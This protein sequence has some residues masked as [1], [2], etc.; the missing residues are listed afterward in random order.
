VKVEKENTRLSA[1]D[2]SNQLACPHLTRL[3]LAVARGVRLAPQWRNP[4]TWVLQQHGL[5]HEQNYLKHLE[6]LGLSIVDLRKVD[7]E[8]EAVKETSIAMKGGVDVVAQ[9]TLRTGRWLGRADVLRRVNVPSRLGAWSYEAYDCKLAQETKAATILQLSL[10]SEFLETAQGI[11]PES[12]HVVPRTKELVAEVYR[13]LDFASYYRQVKSRLEQAVDVDTSLLTYPEPNSH[14]AVCRWWRE[15]DACWRKDDHLSLVAGI[16]K[17]QQKQ[18]LAWNTDTLEK[19]AVLPLP[20]QQRPERGSS[21][22]YI[23]VRE[24]A[25]VQ[26]TSR[27]E[28]SPVF[29]LLPVELECGLTQ[30]PEPSPG[31]FFFDIEGDPFVGHGGLEYLLGLV[32]FTEN[33]GPVYQCRWSQNPVEERNAFEWF[34]DTVMEA[35]SRWPALHVYHFAPYEPSAIKRLMG[36]YAS[37]EDAVD[38]M[39]RASL[40]VDL[41]SIAKQAVR[42]GVEQYSLKSLEELYAFKREVPLREAGYAIRV[43]EHDLELARLLDVG[44]KAP[45]TVEGYNRDDC[46]S[47]LELR[48]WLEQQRSKLVCEGRDVPRPQSEAAEPS[49]KVDERQQRVAALRDKLTNDFPVDLEKQSEEQ[50]ACWLLANLLEW[51]RREEKAE[52]WEFFRLK[53]LADEDLLYE[54]SA[55]AG[56]KWLERLGIDGKLP[57][58]R[59][60]FDPQET[61]IRRE[62]K[63]HHRGERMGTVFAIDMAARTIDIKKTRK[64]ENVHPSSVFSFSHVDSK[65]LADSLFRLGVWVQ[66]NGIDSPGAYRAARDLLLR[67]PP[68]IGGESEASGESCGPLIREGETTL[69]A[70][71]RIALKLDSSVLPVQGP[72]GAGKTYTGAR[73][74][75]EL[76]RMGKKV[77]ISALSHKVIRNLLDETVNAARAMN[78][79]GLRCVQKVKERSEAPSP[80]IHETEDNAETLKALQAAGGQVVAGTGWLWSREEFFETVDVLFVDEAGQMSLANVLAVA[81]AAK[82]IVLLGDPQQL[83]QPLQGSHPDGAEVSALEHLLA[84]VPTV[85]PDRGLFLEKTWRLHPAICSFTSELFYQ[86]RLHS[87]PGLDQ[88]RVHGHPWLSEYGLWF[89]PMD[90]EG[91][92][93]SSPEEVERISDLVKSLL[94]P[95]VTWVNHEGSCRRLAL[96]DVLIITPYN[97]QVSDIAG[98][99]PGARV[100]TVDKFQGQEAP[101]VI[102][103]LTTSSAEEAPRGM[104]FLY[105]LNRLNVATSRARALCILVGSRRLF[106]PECRSPRQMQ[107]ANGWCRY[108]ETA[109]VF[110]TRDI[111]AMDAANKLRTTA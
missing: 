83:E 15:C 27:R 26:A 91:N 10:Y 1:S 23:R 59:Y 51:H 20:L 43:T 90:H 104:E 5:E 53:E 101:V 17:L 77:G 12:M 2:L 68:R 64:T 96:D 33:G 41:H 4:D 35:W 74:I 13:V 93:N 81:Q 95:E 24:Q 21:E 29:E 67:R 32:T 36:R 60:L 28:G 111:G 80:F 100:G 65:E 76:V 79:A 19:L 49:A 37:R 102:Y 30:L 78:L 11:L 69:Q 63:L 25:R 16:S 45:R 72:P 61:D 48:N 84:G 8:E 106:G 56:L 46:F 55:L 66:A 99:I 109:Q 92:Q 14:C 9:A 97:A 22:G 87:R 62:E 105:S 18:L 47:T 31:D 34:V 75:C 54:K 108:L 98:R 6:Q 103:S 94:T 50:R 71:Q 40:F 85:A 88:Q 38:R 58:D 7:S 3:D 42:A 89:V 73:M 57:V 44:E 82:S 39:L 86:G 52:W 110:E 107:L 70:A